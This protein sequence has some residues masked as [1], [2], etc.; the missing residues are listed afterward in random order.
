M[1]TRKYYYLKYYKPT[2]PSKRFRK[3]LNVKLST[4]PLKLSKPFSTRISTPSGRNNSGKIVVAHRGG[5]QKRIFRKIDM[6]SQL[7]TYHKL[8]H[9]EY[10][11]FRTALIGLFISL[12]GTLSY[13]LLPLGFKIGQI[14]KT[15]NFHFVDYDQD[16]SLINTRILDEDKISRGDTMPLMYYPNGT[17]VHNMELYP[18][19]GGQINRAAGT[20]AKILTRLSNGYVLVRLNTN[21]IRYIH[22]KAMAT[23]GYSSNYWSHAVRLG[24]A[25]ASTWLNRRP[26]V[27]GTAMNPV[28]HPHGGGQGKS[29]GGN[30]SVSRTGVLSKGPRTRTHKV[31]FIKATRRFVAGLNT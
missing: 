23:A 17:L 16:K 25:G 2:T 20:K 18:S 22:G 31:G 6:K 4:N 12:N 15:T 7:N 8:I 21:E 28:D 19:A 9:I 13:R 1:S 5:G 14:I 27:R 10:D 11:S 29:K 24:K 26:T 3:E 30:Q